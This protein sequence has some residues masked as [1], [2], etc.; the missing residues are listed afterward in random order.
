MYTTITFLCVRIFA[1]ISYVFMLIIWWHRSLQA[2][3]MKETFY[4]YDEDSRSIDS[5]VSVSSM[6][7]ASGDDDF[8]DEVS[9]EAHSIWL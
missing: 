3:G 8:W 5:E 6:S 9:H 4:G 1:H 2:A 7:Y